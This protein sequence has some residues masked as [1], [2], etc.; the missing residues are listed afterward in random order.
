MLRTSS[1]EAA[2][3]Q[4]CKPCWRL[5]EDDLVSLPKPPFS[6]TG[7]TPEPPAT[8][9]ANSDSNTSIYDR[10]LEMIERIRAHNDDEILEY[11]ENVDAQERNLAQQK[12]SRKLVSALSFGAVNARTPDETKSLPNMWKKSSRELEADDV[13]RHNKTKPLPNAFWQSSV[14]SLRP[15]SSVTPTIV[16]K[17]AG[18]GSKTSRVQHG[19]SYSTPTIYQLKAGISRE[20]T[21]S[22]KRR[23]KIG[24]ETA[25]RVK[26]C[27]Y[28]ALET[29]KRQVKRN[30]VEDGSQ[31]EFVLTY[32]GPQKYTVIIPTESES[33]DN[34]Q[35]YLPNVKLSHA[36]NL[37]D[38]KQS[39]EHQRTETPIEKQMQGAVITKQ[40]VE[41]N[42]KEFRTIEIT[43]PTDANDIALNKR[44]R[45]RHY[46]AGR[47]LGNVR[48]IH[49]SLS[50]S[51]NTTMINRNS[52]QSQ[53]SV[54][55]RYLPRTSMAPAGASAFHHIIYG[56]NDTSASKQND[57]LKVNP[58]DIISTIDTITK[59]KK[60][61]EV[62]TAVLKRQYECLNKMKKEEQRKRT[63]NVKTKQQNVW[64]GKVTVCDPAILYYKRKL[65]YRLTLRKN[66]D[67]CDLDDRRGKSKEDSEFIFR[68]RDRKTLQLLQQ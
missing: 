61:K 57:K 1:N 6:I 3:K 45:R 21:P 23:T 28:A 50:I 43:I 15:R 56:N 64:P 66:L 36:S 51:R 34:Q 16:R 47:T 18:W 33:W 25:L 31:K 12:A 54:K 11:Y 38:T 60:L 39:N 65:P 29:E 62:T 24:C 27:S 7:I 37:W 67:V 53:S 17:Q 5:F 40:N 44:E 10:D 22:S 63:L 19:R 42:P 68:K 49:R 8:T 55:S 59:A 4:Y 35:E 32:K 9:P 46:Q 30:S 58:A 41:E 48:G 2:K 14:G 13:P 20:Q 26:K 52:D